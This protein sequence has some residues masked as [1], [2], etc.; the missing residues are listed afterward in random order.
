MSWEPGEAA[1]LWKDITEDMEVLE[2]DV[3]SRY[4]AHLSI[5]A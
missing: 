2:C 1:M 5:G 4:A 3:R